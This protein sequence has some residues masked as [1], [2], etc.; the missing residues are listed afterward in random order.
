MSHRILITGGAGFIGVH[1]AAELAKDPANTIV[2]ADNFVRGRDDAAF[3]SICERPN[4]ETLSIDLTDRALY[5]RLGGPFDHVYHL[6]AI[7]GV[8]NVLRRPQEVVRVN[9]LSTLF[10]LEWFVAGGGKKFLFSSTSEAYAWTRLFHELP[11]P[12]PE[13]VPLALTDLDN[14]RASYAGSKIFGELAVR[15]I[16]RAH[17]KPFTIVR[18]HNVYG[19]RMGYEHVIPQMFLRA[20]EGQ[21]PFAVYSASHRRA[22]C[23]VADAVRATILAMTT[24]AADGETFNVGNEHEEVEIRELAKRILKHCG[25]ETEIVELEAENDPVARRCPS[26]AKTARLLGFRPS[27]SL[28]EGLAETLAWYREQKR[29]A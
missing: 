21:T 3:R 10:L 19:P 6:A 15:Q 27:V 12:T 8:E 13:D 25:K 20:Q 14:P 2:L 26:M 16:C 17:A 1:L 18:Y 9:A 23:Y 24:D 11:I 4:V 7:I 22:F 28:D 5:S 29:P